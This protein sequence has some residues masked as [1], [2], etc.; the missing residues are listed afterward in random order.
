MMFYSK[1]FKKFKNVSHCFFSRKGGVSKGIY[2]S[3]NCG[4]GSKDKKKNILKN[5]DL[6]SNKIKVKRKNLILMYQTHSNKVTII[7]DKNKNVKRFYSDAIITKIKK[8]A[9]GV[10][11]AELVPILLYDKKNDTI[12]CV[13]AGWTGAK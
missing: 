9:L 11:T 12:G 2:N 5:L 8:F 4:L 7:N 3:L 6:V 13:Q 10:V 1:K